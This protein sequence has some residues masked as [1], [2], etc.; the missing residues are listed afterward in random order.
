M[1]RMQPH[2]V[3]TMPPQALQR[4]LR[5]KAALEVHHQRHSLGQAPAEAS[6]KPT[7]AVIFDHLAEPLAVHVRTALAARADRQHV[8]A[9]S[10]ASQEAPHLDGLALCAS[11][12]RKMLFP[13]Q[14]TC[15]RARPP[16]PKFNVGTCVD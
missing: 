13:L 9:E 8:Q 15:S 6:A 12:K 5:A 3:Q 1:F 16:P 10:T 2:R 4:V 7:Q 11:V 14:T